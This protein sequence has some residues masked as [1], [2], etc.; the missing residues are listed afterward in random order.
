M[1][2]KYLEINL[3]K[4][5]GQIEFGMNP[6]RVIS[7][8]SEYQVYENWM[9]GNLNSSLL[10]QGMILDFDKCDS[11]GLLKTSKFCGVIINSRKDIYLFGR[12]L[13]EW[14]EVEF[15]EM[16]TVN[17]IQF[18]QFPNKA[19]NSKDLGFEIYFDKED[20]SVW[21]EFWFFE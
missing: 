13:I 10:Y 9:G 12:K 4:G 19:I 18:E 6:S 5:I 17:N 21:L 7:I 11:V 14:N 15:I 3:L 1:S 20:D 2:E 16:L 8:M